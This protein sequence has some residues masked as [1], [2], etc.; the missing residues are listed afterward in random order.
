MTRK[1]YEPPKVE[2]VGEVSKEEA[3]EI[4]EPCPDCK[5]PILEH[6]KL[7]VRPDCCV[8]GCA[9]PGLL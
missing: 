5:H 4:D 3:A 6:G 9:C 1:P 7:T 8:T 2:T